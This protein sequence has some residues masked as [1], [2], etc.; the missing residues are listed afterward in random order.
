MNV[1]KGQTY[2]RGESYNPENPPGIPSTSQRRQ[3]V[4]LN[5]VESADGLQYR[6]ILFNQRQP[7][8]GLTQTT[9]DAAIAAINSVRPGVTLIDTDNDG[10][11]DETDPDDDNDGIRDSDEVILGTD[12]LLADSDGNGTNDG[13]E[14]S[15]G[16]RYTDAQELNLLETDPR[17]GNSRFEPVFQRNGA[18]GELRFPTIL[19]RRY[20]VEGTS[21]L[22]EF[23]EV[24]SIL[25]TGNE[26]IVDLGA[27]NGTQ[28]FRVRVEIASAN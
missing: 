3:L 2:Y 8:S 21:D 25:G 4:I 7:S 23:R 17:D 18:N 20:T 10:D 12:P 16:D 9:A 19:G 14:N 5:M 13:D 26:M 15:D 27:V 22:I 1:R 24:S 28:L 6:E 11:P